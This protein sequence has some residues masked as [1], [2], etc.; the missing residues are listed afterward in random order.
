MERPS[1][2]VY[3]K[4][5]HGVSSI[6]GYEPPTIKYRSP[7][8]AGLLRVFHK[9]YQLIGINRRGHNL[10]GVFRPARLI[11]MTALAMDTSR[12]TLIILSG[13]SSFLTLQLWIHGKLGY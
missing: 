6:S 12:W 10:L 13:L 2:G 3:T 1:A 7:Q 9:T 4:W 8:R 5:K 11:S